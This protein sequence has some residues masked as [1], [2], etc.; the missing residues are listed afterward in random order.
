MEYFDLHC[1]LVPLR[2][3]D[4]PGE[5]Q[6]FLV[7]DAPAIIMVHCCRDR[8]LRV[9]SN[10]VVTTMSRVC[11]KVVSSNLHFDFAGPSNIDV[12][13]EKELNREMGEVDCPAVSK[14]RDPA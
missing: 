3:H 2:V 10:A 1:V 7:T 4:L 13:G 8:R 11:Q 12:K 14:T 6:T 9:L 5:F